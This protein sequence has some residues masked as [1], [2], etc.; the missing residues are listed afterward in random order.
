MR[1]PAVV[2]IGNFDGVHTGHRAL[3]ARARDLCARIGAARVVA[4]VFDPSPQAVLT[5]RGPERLST[6]SQRIDWLKACGADEVV[7]LEP[8]R[9]LLE[10]EPDRFVRLAVER[11]HAAGFVEGPDFCFGKSR[12]G[13]AQTLCRLAAELNLVAEIMPPVEVVL[14]DHLRVE[15]RSSLVRW[16]L[17]QGR[18]AD[19]RRVLGRP[20]QLVGTVV[21]G[22]RRGRTIGY[23]TVNLRTD[24]AIPAD[25]VYAATATLPDG[26]EL[27]AALSIGTKPTFGA[28]ARAIEAYLF[29]P[30]TVNPADPRSGTGEALADGDEVA[31]FPP[32]TGG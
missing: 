32:V 8:S 24:L 30:L 2:T 29:D 5:G 16:L 31:F 14:D 27:A 21:Q 3:V 12:S 28:C 25:G 17:A 10:L 19:A 1:Q 23:P 9:E 18:V 26:R 15:A 22:D 13:N 7:H 20:Y 11:W 6:L 4:L